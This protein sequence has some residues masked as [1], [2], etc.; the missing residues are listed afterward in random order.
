MDV[1]P[2]AVGDTIGY[3]LPF[4]LFFLP[5]GYRMYLTVS[6]HHIDFS[7]K[8]TFQLWL[9]EI[10]TITRKHGEFPIELVVIRIERFLCL[11]RAPITPRP[12]TV[13]LSPVSHCPSAFIIPCRIP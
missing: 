5:I 13:P 1:A 8:L 12:I 3:C 10:I 2:C 9:T 6:S 11:E 7:I 4:I